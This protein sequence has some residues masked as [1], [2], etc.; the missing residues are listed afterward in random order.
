GQ[1][2]GVIGFEDCQKVIA[3]RPGWTFSRLA[4]GVGKRYSK[5]QLRI[6]LYV[7]DWYSNR[8]GGM[9]H[10][11]RAL[12]RQSRVRTQ[13]PASVPWHAADAEDLVVVDSTWG[14]LQPLHCAPNV[15]TVGEL[16][17]IEAVKNGAV[18]VGSCLPDSWSGGTI[19]WTINLSADK[20]L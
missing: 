12:Y 5:L 1:A 16:E 3:G 9:G 6:P 4:F 11:S 14:E 18:I 7:S 19:P 17:L 20:L 8:V 13:E 2:P 15:V 10:T